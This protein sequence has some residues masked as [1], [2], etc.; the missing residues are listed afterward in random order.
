MNKTLYTEFNTML[1]RSKI[2]ISAFVALF[3]VCF[4]SQ[5]IAQSKHEI[6]SQYLKSINRVVDTQIGVQAQKGGTPNVVLGHQGK[7]DFEDGAFPPAGWS[8]HVLDGDVANVWENRTGASGYGVGTRASRYNFYDQATEGNQDSLVSPTLTGLKAADTLMFDWAYSSFNSGGPYADSLEA[9]VSYDDGITWNQVFVKWGTNDAANDLRTAPMTNSSFVPISTQ[10]KTFKHPLGGD[11]VGANVRIMLRT[12]NHYGNHLWIDNIQTKKAQAEPFDLTGPANGSSPVPLLPNLVWGVSDGAVAY[13]VLLDQTPTPTTV[14]RANLN[15]TSFVAGPLAPATQYF[16]TV[17]AKSN[18]GVDVPAGS[19]FSFTTGTPPATPSNLIVSNPTTSTLDLAWTDNATNETGYRVYRS[20]TGVVGSFEQIGTDLAQDANMYNDNGPLATATRYYYEVRAV[21]EVESEG[22]PGNKATLAVTADAATLG[23]ESYHYIPVIAN[24]GSNPDGTEMSIQVEGSEF[25]KSVTKFVGNGGV[26]VDTPVWKSRTGWGGATGTRASGLLSGTSYTFRVKARNPDNVAVPDF[27]ADA[28]KSTKLAQNIDVATLFEQFTNTTVWPP[29]GWSHQDVDGD[30]NIANASGTFGRWHLSTTNLYSAGGSSRTFTWDFPAQIPGA[31]GGTAKYLNPSTGLEEN[32]PMNDILF[33]LPLQLTGG[34]N[35]NVTFW[36]RTVQGRAHDIGIVLATRPFQS[37]VIDTIS[38]RVYDTPGAYFQDGVVFTPPST[39]VYYIGFWDHSPT[40]RVTIRIEDVRIRVQPA[41]DLLAQKITQENEFPELGYSD[42][43]RASSVF[44]TNDDMPAEYGRTKEI[45]VNEVGRPADTRSYSKHYII[46]TPV[47]AAPIRLKSGVNSTSGV[48]TP[49]INAHEFVYNLGNALTGA[50]WNI[51]WQPGETGPGLTAAGVNIGSAL[52]GEQGSVDLDYQPPSVGTYYTLST[53]DLPGDAD[54][55]NDTVRT[56]LLAYPENYLLL[57]HDSA[58]SGP[59]VRT[60]LTGANPLAGAMQFTVPDDKF[61]RVVG[62]YSYYKNTTAAGAA[63]PNDSIVVKIH[64]AGADTT[65]KRFNGIDSFVVTRPTVGPTA[66]SKT[67]RGRDYLYTLGSF[68]QNFALP[69]DES[70]MSYGPGSDFFLS[71]RM[72]V[73][74]SSPLGYSDQLQG[75]VSNPTPYR[76]WSS[77]NGGNTWLTSASLD[78]S[79]WFIKA[80]TQPVNGV[81]GNL[82]TDEDGDPDT[83]DD[84]TAVVGGEISLYDADQNLVGTLTTGEDGSATFA[85]GAE[86]DFLPDG[87][88]TVSIDGQEGYT[89][90][91]GTSTSVT[92]SGGEIESVD[93]LVFENGSVSGYLFHDVDGDGNWGDEDAITD[94]EVILSL[95]GDSVAS[96]MSDVDGYYEFTDL[97]PG[98]YSVSEVLPD[99][100]GESVSPDDI[101]ATSGFDASDSDFGSYIGGSVSGYA[102]LD[103]NENDTKDIDESGIAGIVVSLDEATDKTSTN[104]APSSTSTTGE[105]GGYSFSVI[106]PGSYDLDVAGLGGLDSRTEGADGYTGL[107]IDGTGTEFEDKNFGFL[108][109]GSISG[110]VYSD[111]NGDGDKDAEDTT[112]ISGATVTLTIGDESASATTDADGMYSFGGLAE[113]NYGVSASLPVGYNGKENSSGTTVEL[114]AA[115]SSTVNFGG[116]LDPTKFRTFKE[117]G[118]WATKAVKLKIKAGVVTGTPNENTVVENVFNRSVGKTGVTLLGVPTD[119]KTVAKTRSWLLFKKASAIAAFYTSAHDGQAYP[120]DSVRTAGKKSKVMGKALTPARKKYNNKFWAQA[121][122]LRLNILA[123]D[124]GVTPR[125]FGGLVLDTAFTLVGKELEN[126]TLSQI[127]KNADTIASL[128]DDPTVTLGRNADRSVDYTNL[129]AF[130][131]LLKRIND[132]FY[133]AMAT[134]NFAIDTTNL[135]TGK[136]PF[137]VKL[138]GAKAAYEVGLVKNLGKTSEPFV[139]QG[140]YQ[141][142]TPLTFELSQNYPNPFNPT[143][144][145]NIGI[146]EEMDGALATMKVYN[147]LGQEVA[148]LLNGEALEAGMNEVSFDAANIPSGVYFYRVSLNGGA[149]TAMKK[150][151][152]LK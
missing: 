65:Y 31:P 77:V 132:G 82:Y 34:T 43:K 84:R 40:N 73:G 67:F 60:S 42:N 27:S 9:L 97:G 75:Q 21:G 83:D 23:T 56:Y 108:Y 141:E 53:I 13:D 131:D 147:V 28:S 66:F 33:S 98:T 25:L 39:G 116:Q 117:G 4:A 80:F 135:Q 30:G 32:K 54:Y 138:S 35:Y 104:P 121:V 111:V 2:L 150:M 51:D 134:D 142:E 151:M 15:A 29:E 102:Y 41:F 88:Y 140:G 16:W 55:S 127:A 63:L 79:V 95:D 19:V 126:L 107:E 119:D 37:S 78:S 61:L 74:N 76:S 90:P 14:V 106:A 114:D 94:R 8:L 112:G 22:A 68:A 152:L 123:S 58:G 11:V 52:P 100:W 91:L 70:G 62:L 20:L 93:I 115:A 12:L 118:A 71:M 145:I 1:Q 5:S 139:I 105:D 6:K 64:D 133:A 17:K 101:A 136:K 50:Q 110:M 85:P 3:I 120:I 103:A 87:D 10:W 137:A 24:N 149:Y 86:N 59:P 46:N 36:Y 146:P 18:N 122:L 113:G 45:T 125:N 81:I 72:G 124:T 109:T 143:T 89:Y 130:A 57:D 44:G 47:K 48:E 128:Y 99:G 49:E 7:I 96:A 92:V 144:V 129:G 148:T 69:L 38:D 26:L